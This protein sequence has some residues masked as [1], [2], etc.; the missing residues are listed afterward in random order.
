MSDLK[1]HIGAISQQLEQ[2]LKVVHTE[3]ELEEL[4]IAFLGRT[5]HIAAIMTNLKSLSL[6]EKK[7]IGPLLNNLKQ[8]AEQS[9]NN[10]KQ[11]ILDQKELL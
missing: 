8:F 9:Y 4:R 3:K 5:G 6:D 7:E 10:K 1:Q 11:I 2:A